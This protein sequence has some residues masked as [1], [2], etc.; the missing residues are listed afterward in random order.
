MN[1]ILANKISETCTTF[2][3]IGLRSEKRL[4]YH[5]LLE[6]A[7]ENNLLSDISNVDYIKGNRGSTDLQPLEGLEMFIDDIYVYGYLSNSNLVNKGGRTLL[8]SGETGHAKKVVAAIQVCIGASFGVEEAFIPVQIIQTMATETHG[9][10]GKTI[11]SIER[12]TNN[13]CIDQWKYIT[14]EEPTACFVAKLDVSKVSIQKLHQHLDTFQR[15]LL[16]IGYNLYCVDYTQDFSGTLHRPTLI[17]FLLS[18]GY[19]KQGDFI[20]AFDNDTPTILENTSSVGNNVCTWIS[21]ENGKTIRVKLY[22]KIVSNFE[23]GEVQSQFGGHL[24]DYADCSNEHMKQTFTHH[25]VQERGCTRVEVSLYAYERGEETVAH[26]I[27]QESLEM[28]SGQNLFFIQPAPN[29]WSCLAEQIDRCCV[30]ANRPTKTIN[31]GWYANTKTGK[32]AGIEFVVKH[33]DNWEK[34]VQW[35]ISEFGFKNCPIFRIDIHDIQKNNILSEDGITIGKLRCYTKNAPTILARARKPTEVHNDPPCL[36]QLLPPTN[37]IEWE[38]RTKKTKHSI[39]VEKI[40]HEILEVPT[41]REISTL[42]VNKRKHRLLELIESGKVANWKLEKERQL[43]ENINERIKEFEIVREAVLRKNH[44]ENAKRQI[45]DLVSDA[46]KNYSPLKLV[47]IPSEIT[48]ILVLGF[49]LSTSTARMVVSSTGKTIDGVYWASSP[50]LRYLKCIA[51]NNY[52][53]ADKSTYY[54][55]SLLSCPQFSLEGIK[56][57]YNSEGK[58]IS[59]R[60]SQPK[61]SSWVSSLKSSIDNIEEP[62]PAKSSYLIRIDPPKPNNTIQTSKM[63]EGEYVCYQYATTTYRGK[64][65]TILFLIATGT[66]EEIPTYGP[67]LQEE[68]EKL[69]LSTC[70]APIYCRIGEFKHTKSRHKDRTVSLVAQHSALESRT[71]AQPIVQLQKQ[72][73]PI[74]IDIA[75]PTKVDIVEPTKVDELA[76][77]DKPKKIHTTSP[78]KVFPEISVKKLPPGNYEFEEYYRKQIGKKGKTRIQ[79]HLH[80]VDDKGKRIGLRNVYS[81]YGSVIEKEIAKID[82]ENTLAPVCCVLQVLSDGVREFHILDTSTV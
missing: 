29:Q 1:K 77:V 67:F 45:H 42:S 66:T 68:V 72:V 3:E 79:L 6:N 30:I 47:E 49:R 58:Q 43:Q 19:N 73:S 17:N 12:K 71:D 37:F 48:N 10:V 21:T 28:F 15:H 11:E 5:L 70:M 64:P 55:P 54:F 32:I 44:A 14:N 46:F 63:N 4:S 2:K 41:T 8:S 39:G 53:C 59:Y 33:M 60:P 50:I 82:L 36:Q 38:W 56:T 9:I 40:R 13:K 22:N 52:C 16:A 61:D 75:E 35:S 27:M 24:A 74:K 62:I 78:C 23:A 51:D 76:K 81:A 31:I 18:Q 65:K 25:K 34:A 26:N 57:F 20:S 69:D 7:Y 80:A